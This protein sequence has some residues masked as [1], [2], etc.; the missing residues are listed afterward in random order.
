MKSRAFFAL[1][2]LCVALIP[3]CA[4]KA[5][6]SARFLRYTTLQDGT[7]AAVVAPLAESTEAQ[8]A[9]TDIADLKANEIV[10]VRWVGRSWE[11]PQWKP[12]REIVSR[13]GED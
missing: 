7:R 1:I 3:G 2:I 6:Y 11:T 9:Y 10:L 5:D 4:P 12:E 8:T 13:T